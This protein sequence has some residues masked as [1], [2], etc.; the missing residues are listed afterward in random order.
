[1]TDYTLIQATKADFGTLLKLRLMTMPAHLEKAGIYLSLQEHKD[2]VNEDYTSSYLILKGAELVGMLKYQALTGRFNIMQL[3]IFPA[4][5]SQGIGYQ[6]LNQLI[7]NRQGRPIELTVLKD[8]PAKHLYQRL[9]FI[10]IGED[11]YESFMQL[12]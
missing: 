10:V 11:E 3:Q 8:N 9:G 12:N 4:F 1:M 2:R 7:Q 5:Q 6:V